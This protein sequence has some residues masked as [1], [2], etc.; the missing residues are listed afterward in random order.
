MQKCCTALVLF[1]AMR[2]ACSASSIFL[3]PAVTVHCRPDNSS[4][5]VQVT[6]K[7]DES[8]KSVNATVSLLDDEIA[9][10]IEPSLEPAEIRAFEMGLPE[11]PAMPGFY[12]VAVTIRCT[13]KEGRP[14][15][16][17]MCSPLLVVDEKSLDRI[18]QFK[19][20]VT[21]KLSSP[22]LARTRMMTLQLEANGEEDIEGS[23]RLFLPD[24]IQCLNPV[25]PVTMRAGSR[26]TVPFELVDRDALPGCRHKVFAILDYVSDGQHRSVVTHGMVSIPPASKPFAISHAYWIIL[27]IVLVASFFLVQL[28]GKKKPARPAE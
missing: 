3:D 9:G 17:V 24:E 5:T 13:N 7:G 25:V 26:S 19:D 27:I 15:S 4:V 11:L 10:E 8:A 12:T 6:N 23:I 1:L 22:D 21:T 18:Q 16:L 14:L 28:L 2:L 20:C